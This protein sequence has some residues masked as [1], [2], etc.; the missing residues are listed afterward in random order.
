MATGTWAGNPFASTES[1]Q[2]SGLMIQEI[3][4]DDFVIAWFCTDWGPV[5]VGE[6]IQLA[7]FK[8]YNRCF[9]MHYLQG[10]PM[11]LRSYLSFSVFFRDTV[12]QILEM[13][14]WVICSMLIASSTIPCEIL[15]ADKK[16]N[17]SRRSLWNV[18]L[19]IREE[20]ELETL[21]WHCFT[22]LTTVPR[23]T[24]NPDLLPKSRSM[25]KKLHAFTARLGPWM[26]E[27]ATCTFDTNRFKFLLKLVN[28]SCVATA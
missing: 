16:R 8:K 4:I 21:S 24:C 18:S 3:W 2:N 10:F 12:L 25:R 9:L 6:Q 19:Q 20:A 23:Q 28:Q 26:G 7:L 13:W 1:C 11:Q 22:T 5:N 15:G 17:K 14:G 27:R